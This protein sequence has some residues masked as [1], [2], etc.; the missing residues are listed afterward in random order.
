MAACMDFSNAIGNLNKTEINILNKM[1]LATLL[2]RAYIP[3]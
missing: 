1:C 2:S 3:V